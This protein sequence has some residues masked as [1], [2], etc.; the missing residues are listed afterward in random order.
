M[1]RASW[2]YGLILGL[3][4]IGTFC[5]VLAWSRINDLESE[6]QSLR[7]RVSESSGT[8]PEAGEI[9][10]LRREN[11]EI[12]LLRAELKELPQLR[13]D[14]QEL[15]RLRKGFAALKAKSTNTTA[16]DT[17]PPSQAPPPPAVPP[18]QGARLGVSV[19]GVSEERQL[20]PS[21]DLPEGV[22]VKQIMP[23]SPAAQ[24]GLSANDVILDV[25]GNPVANA[26]DF[27]NA[28][29][30]RTPGLPVTLDVFRQGTRLRIVSA[31]D[32]WSDQPR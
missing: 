18:N 24:S 27:K 10:R 29:S 26:I 20:N 30:Q 4:A 17:S 13:A 9:E 23:N 31:T 32:N 15:F 16:G 3:V 5:G 12:P 25:D 22:L 11:Q 6:N 14:Y 21:L 7:T 28:V 19:A 8:A 2:L 1:K